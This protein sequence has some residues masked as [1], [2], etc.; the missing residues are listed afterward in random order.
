MGGVVGNQ[1]RGRSAD[2]RSR[3]HIRQAR[4]NARTNRAQGAY[5]IAFS[6]RTNVRV[7]GENKV[8]V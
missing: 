8:G 3:L 4:G 7:P 5:G 1:P 2:A 6:S